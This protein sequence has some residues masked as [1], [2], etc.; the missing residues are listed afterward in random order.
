M[1]CYTSL[2]N[3]LSLLYF[4]YF[5]CF[6]YFVI[7]FILHI[8]FDIFLIAFVNGKMHSDITAKVH[9]LIASYE[10]LEPYDMRRLSSDGASLN[11]CPMS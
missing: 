8:F 5:A 3:I 1:E 4:V 9:P 2:N 10:Q 11:A 7:R 6:A